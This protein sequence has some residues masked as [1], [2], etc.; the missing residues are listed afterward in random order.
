MLFLKSKSR[1][2]KI[3]TIF[4]ALLSVGTFFLVSCVRCPPN[5]PPVAVLRANP[6]SG[7][8]PLEVTFDISGSSDPDGI[9]MSYSLDFGDGTTPVTGTDIT[10]PI[11]HTYT[12]AGGFTATLTVTDNRGALGKDSVV[13]TVKLANR[14][15]VADSQSVATE[16]DTP[17]TVILTGSDP[18][19]DLLT[20]NII[21]PPTN[22]SLS[23]VSQLSPTS[24]QVTYNPNA[25]FYGSDSFSFQVSDGALDSS[26]ATVSISITPVNDAPIPAIS[27]PANN[28]TF[29]QGQAITFQG[30]ANDVEDGSLT[31]AS[32]VWTSSIDGQIGTGESFTRNDLSIGT[33]TITL[34]ATDSQG[35]QGTDSVTIIVNPPLARTWYVDDDF[36]DCPNA[37]FNKIQDAIDAASPGDTVK[38]CPG[39]Y[40]E[41]LVITKSLTLKG[42]GYENTVI[43]GGI[44]IWRSFYETP[45]EVTVE[46]LKAMD[47]ISIAHNVRATIR[48]NYLFSEG[49]GIGVLVAQAV[50]EGNYYIGGAY[51]EGILV[52]GSGAKA[53]IRNNRKIGG[54]AGGIVVDNGT[55]AIIEG[56]SEIRGCYGYG[57]L[58]EDLGLATIERNTISYGSSG[59]MV[60]GEAT[61]KENSIINNVHEGIVV[62][63]FGQAIILNNLISGNGGGIGMKYSAKTT[64]Q[65]NTISGN[66]YGGI[67]M[68]DSAYATILENQ[69]SKNSTGIVMR[70]SAYATILENQISENSTGI[71]IMESA[72]ATITGNTISGHRESGILMRDS[73]QA[74]IEGN[75]ITENNNYGVVLYQRP[76]YDTDS[77]FEGA[78]RGRRNEISGNKKGE[79]CPTELGFLMTEAG[80]C[81]GPKC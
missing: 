44:S 75:K 3:L 67:G 32:L 10:K 66:T 19:G 54:G 16:E 43:Q 4:L 35:A 22:G 17:L 18:D 23:S 47:G 57:V 79:V 28:S 15:P 65:G 12:T 9:I 69:I 81:Y 80:G 34:V 26:P 77:I 33:H 25:N 42:A 14:P 45:I 36:R 1:G 63:G 13:I 55:E 30:S 48:D 5:Q 50:I 59:I 71:V 73:A 76:C 24:A 2:I 31:G 39:T 37:D 41:S 8:A 6:S 64:I 7:T 58:V 38:V 60:L 21:T 29:T 70:G 56:N 53:T 46:S 68:M 61:I 51:N 49:I 72:Q 20:F 40:K 74:T 11:L 62:D 78:V 52:S 27:S